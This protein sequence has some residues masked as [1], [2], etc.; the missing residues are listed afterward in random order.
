MKKTLIAL[1][2]GASTLALGGVTLIEKDAK[3]ATI[4]NIPE[5]VETLT[6]QFN[7]GDV[8][9]HTSTVDSNGLIT[10][11]V[12]EKKYTIEPLKL[13]TDKAEGT[14][15]KST[16]L[17]IESIGEDVYIKDAWGATTDI[18]LTNTRDSFSK[19]VSF[20]QDDFKNLAADTKFIE[21]KFQITGFEIPDGIYSNR[22]E[23]QPNVWLEKGKAWDSSGGDPNQNYTDVEFEVVGNTLIKR[24]PVE[25]FKTATF[26]VYTDAV[27]TFGTK[28]YLD[29]GP[30][31]TADVL[32]IGENK[33]VTCWHD[34]GDGTDEVECQV[35]TTTGT[36]IATGTI[37][38]AE[39]D[40]TNPVLTN[41][42]IMGACAAGNDRWVV[43]YNED[44]PA[45]TKDLGRARVASSTGLTIN[46]YGPEFTF[47]TGTTTA[48]V[49]TYIGTDKVLIAY[50][51]ATNSS[52]QGGVF[53]KACT[54]GTDYT[55][56]CGDQKRF[57]AET[58]SVYG[59]LSCATL[60]T[61]KFICYYDR[62]NVGYHYLNVGTVSG[63]TITLGATTTLS[64]SNED[65]FGHNLAALS[66][67]AFFVTTSETSGAA[68]Q[69]GAVGTVS[70][71]TIT[72]GATTT[73]IST[74][75]SSLT[76]IVPINSSSALW[77]GQYGT[78]D[79]STTT[80]SLI[81]ITINEV[82]RTFSTSTPETI[83]VTTDPGSNN[84]AKIGDCKYAFAWEDDN[85]TNDLFAIIGDTAGCV[86]D[87]VRDAGLIW[88]D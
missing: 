67:T 28:E 83:D 15:G 86:V 30:S 55:L 60:D 54:I 4:T 10:L 17:N 23:I 31:G 21:V 8:P 1:F 79:A 43:V 80:Y 41:N 12:G 24:I 26:P 72:L 16:A 64:T 5:Q 84:A 58:S 71:T 45:G 35:A 11:D 85:G 39:T 59:N 3:P 75:A 42:N 56:T 33:F 48:P 87:S 7:F 77:V 65:T 88:F 61:D 9:P 69:Y 49:C 51:T 76:T 73:R 29:T 62:I 70:G 32:K 19:V 74:L 53:A 81:P 78:V 36:D 40:A 18:R 52:G 22:I 63:T 34:N 46:G 25:W 20:T 13:E 50:A 44:N 47:S 38:V 14:K 66:P 27:F 82:A 37:A 6:N 68:P 57:E 2:F